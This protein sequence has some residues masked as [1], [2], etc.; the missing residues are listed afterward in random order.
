MRRLIICMLL[1]SIPLVNHATDYYS[2][3]D[4]I[5]I[6][7]T[8]PLYMGGGIDSIVLENQSNNTIG[9]IAYNNVT[10]IPY[11]IANNP[12]PYIH[13]DYVCLMAVAESVFTRDEIEQYC[14]CPNFINM[15]L[16]LN[17][18]TGRVLEVKFYLGCRYNDNTILSI[19]VDKIE[20]LEAGIKTS[21]VCD[22]PEAH[23]NATFLITVC[24]LFRE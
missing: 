17:P 5:G 4:S 14:D 3:R 22:I 19:P 12:M 21:I 8:R 9:T 24:D 23:R 7:N 2:G 10:G 13:V 18:A 6:Y 16:A 11:S 20:A 1:A 15:T